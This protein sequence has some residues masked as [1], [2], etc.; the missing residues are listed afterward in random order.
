[1]WLPA[2]PD[3]HMEVTSMLAQDN[4]VVTEAMVR[5]T[6]TGT[7]KMWVTEPVPATKKD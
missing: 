2:F 4:C 3:T 7:L 1:M 6:H 5:A